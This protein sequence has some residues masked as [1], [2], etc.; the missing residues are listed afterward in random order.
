MV[1]FL[2][3]SPIARVHC[4]ERISCR[5]VYLVFSATRICSSIFKIRSDFSERFFC[6]KK[7]VRGEIARG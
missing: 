1:V 5:S 6:A 7:S 3:D 2:S 4:I